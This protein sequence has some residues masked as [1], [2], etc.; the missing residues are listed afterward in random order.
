MPTFAL[1]SDISNKFHTAVKLD[2]T[3]HIFYGNRFLEKT[4]PAFFK[5]KSLW[6]FRILQKRV[7]P[8]I[9]AP[10]DPNYFFF[11]FVGKRF[12]RYH[13]CFKCFLIII[14]SSCYSCLVAILTDTIPKICCSS[15]FGLPVRLQINCHHIKL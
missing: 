11:S 15:Y 9:L 4:K 14:K 5:K 12:H 2:T 3:D 8:D 10:I 6:K 7:I 1:I 13:F